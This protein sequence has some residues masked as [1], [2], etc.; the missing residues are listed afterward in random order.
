MTIPGLKVLDELILGIPLNAQQRREIAHLREQIEALQ[1][2]NEELRRKNSLNAPKPALSAESLKILLFLFQHPS[3]MLVAEE[4][5]HTFGLQTGIAKYHCGKLMSQGYIS[6]S[7]R[8]MGD[9]TYES[10][11]KIT[12]A[13]IAYLVEN[14]LAQ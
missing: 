7:W 14:G 10:E 4:L 9:G 12:D 1:R 5:G 6:D 3:D 8:P 13:G 2:E 11:F